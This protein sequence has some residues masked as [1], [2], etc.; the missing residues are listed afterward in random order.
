MEYNKSRSLQI[1]YPKN[2][3]VDNSVIIKVIEDS[4]VIKVINHTIDRYV[5]KKGNYRVYLYVLD[6]HNSIVFTL[7][8]LDKYEFCNKF[9]DM[10]NIQ[11]DW[12]ETESLS[13]LK[14]MLEVLESLNEF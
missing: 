13:E 6:E 12:P 2:F 5:D 14:H 3:E 7:L 8:D 1:T 10:R 9:L 4:K 11:G